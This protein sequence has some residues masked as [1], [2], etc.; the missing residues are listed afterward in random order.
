MFKRSSL[1]FLA[2]LTAFLSSCGDER[3]EEEIVITGSS[4]VAPVVSEAARQ[5]ESMTPGLR[6]DVQTGG[7]SRGIADVRKGLAHLGM[8][9]RRLKGDESDLSVRTIAIDGVGVIV[10]RENPIQDL[11]KDQLVGI[12]RKEISNWKELGGHDAPIIVVN[13]AEGRATLEVFLGYTGLDSADVKADVIAGENQHAIKSV[14][15]NP[16]AIGYVSIG[17]AAAES[18][19]GIPV[20]LIACDGIEASTE[21]VSNGTFPIVRPLNMVTKG[22]PSTAAHQFLEYLGSPAIH[23][24]IKAHLYVPVEH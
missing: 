12:Y 11:S 16:D 5:Y 2:F 1:T 19:A 18:D 21:N 3:S 6:I 23:G 22:A 17:A 4:T 13:K 24:N 15:G 9:S 20:K 14:A 10:H 7:S 8:A